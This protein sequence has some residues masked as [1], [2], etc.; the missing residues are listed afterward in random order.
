[1]SESPESIECEIMIDER[2]CLLGGGYQNGKYALAVIQTRLGGSGNLKQLSD[3]EE[4]ASLLAE[5][6][7]TDLEVERTLK[8][9]HTSRQI[10]FRRFVPYSFI[11]EHGF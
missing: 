11:R 5:L 2:E 4:L 9:L 8:S 3:D 6:G 7:L 1:M 10:Q